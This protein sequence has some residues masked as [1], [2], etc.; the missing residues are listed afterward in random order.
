MGGRRKEN[1]LKTAS[2]HKNI[3]EHTLIWFRKDGKYGS[4]HKSGVRR[5]N[6]SQP[7]WKKTWNLKS[8]MF[9][10]YLEPRSFTWNHAP[11]WI[12]IPIPGTLFLYL[13]PYILI[14]GNLFLYQWNPVSVPG[15]MFLY[16][17]PYVTT[18]AVATM[19]YTWNSFDSK[20]LYHS[21]EYIWVYIYLSRPQSSKHI[22]VSLNIFR[23]FQNIYLRMIWHQVSWYIVYI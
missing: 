16:L 6:I 14:P 19:F 10:L 21:R 13:E 15:T 20:Y 23:H 12:Y 9:L 5:L 22:M 11:T 3:A 2:K 17:E 8:T 4:K 1:W 7:E 18:L